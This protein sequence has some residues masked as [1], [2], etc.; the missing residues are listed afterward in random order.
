MVFLVPGSPAKAL[1]WRFVRINE[2]FEKFKKAPLAVQTIE[3]PFSSTSI[4]WK[5][6]GWRIRTTDCLGRYPIKAER[7]GGNCIRCN[8]IVFV[9][10]RLGGYTMCDRSGRT[11]RIVF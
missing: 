10:L 11:S 8:T 5:V 2:A 9:D 7:H 3:R 1:N 4:W 6:N